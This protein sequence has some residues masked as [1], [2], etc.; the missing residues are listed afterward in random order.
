M[1][2]KQYRHL[3]YKIFF[4]LVLLFILNPLSYSFKITVGGLANDSLAYIF[5]GNELIT[6]GKFYLSSWGHIDNALIL[7]PLY[8]ALIGLLNLINHDGIYN[9][10]LISSLTLLFTSIPLFFL[11]LRLSKPTVAFFAVLL[12]QFNYLTLIYGT[13]PLTEPIFIFMLIFLVYLTSRYLSSSRP[14]FLAFIIGLFACLLFFSRQIGIFYLAVFPLI[15]L[16]QLLNNPYNASRRVAVFFAGFLLLFIPYSLTI[17][18]QTGHGPFTQTFRMHEY[19]VEDGAL[20]NNVITNEKETDYNTVYEQRREL[21]RLLPNSREMMG[22]VISPSSHTHE[23][24]VPSIYGILLNLYHNFRNCMIM[25]GNGISFIFILACLSSLFFY[26]KEKKPER[27]LIPVTVFAYIFTLSL[28]TG[29]IGRYL[30]VLYPLLATHI[31]VE[32]SLVSKMAFINRQ[33][34]SWLISILLFLLLLALTPKLFTK[35]VRFPRLS[36]KNSTIEHC[37]SLIEPGSP[38]FSIHPLDPYLL[39]GRYLVLPNDNLEK[40]ATYAN[41][42]GV[43]WLFLDMS[44]VHDREVA[45]YK[46][47]QWLQEKRLPS[48]VD[49]DYE[50]RCA[51]P[52]GLAQLYYIKQTP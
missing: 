7:P 12:F 30:M 29:I 3:D 34:L 10:E 16:L 52:D 49:P 25:L 47:S 32:G 42:T 2:K 38:I 40:I 45:L 9:A 14:N 27:L 44:G 51:T 22:Y 1:L 8:P 21:R 13:A 20:I 17:Y 31:L 4:L 41:F 39:G 24:R 50:L 28:V 43:K 35:A 23:I 6:H 37:K 11:T 19:V 26:F 5:F 15:A 46:H 18:L 36:E 48:E 33:R